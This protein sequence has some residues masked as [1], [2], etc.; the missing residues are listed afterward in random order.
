MACFL[1][2]GQN[3]TPC[4]TPVFNV[5]LISVRTDKA[6][7]MHP[8]HQR[9][10]SLFRPE[11]LRAPPFK[12]RRIAFA[13]IAFLACRNHV[14]FC[15][16]RASFAFGDDVVNGHLFAGPPAISTRALPKRSAQE[17]V[18]QDALAET[19]FCVSRAKFNERLQQLIGTIRSA[20]NTIELS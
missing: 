19:S 16:V 18:L 9:F 6:M 7:A 2:D 17:I 4:L 5:L 20:H 13:Q 8:C 14:V 1:V 3:K 12:E 15:K 11:R 10:F